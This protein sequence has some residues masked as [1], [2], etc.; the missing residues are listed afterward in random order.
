MHRCLSSKE[1]GTLAP[2][3]GSPYAYMLYKKEMLEAIMHQRLQERRESVPRSQSSSPP[4]TTSKLQQSTSAATASDLDSSSESRCSTPAIG[5]S[6]MSGM[7][8]EKRNRRRAE[9]NQA[10]ISDLCEIVADLFIAEAK[11]LN[12]LNYGVVEEEKSTTYLHTST[13]NQILTLR[14]RK[15]LQTVQLFVSS[16][17]TRYALGVETPSEVLVHMRLMSAVRADTTK[18]VV[19]I[20]NL[21]EP[22]KH[23]H[24]YT[25][26]NTTPTTTT[27]STMLTTLS[28][29]ELKPVFPSTPPHRKQQQQQ[30]QTNRRSI[31]LVTIACGDADGLL[32]YIT[33]L[34]GTGG[35][36][37]LDADVMLS[38]DNIVLVC[39]LFA[40]DHCVF[41][42]TNL[43]SM[44]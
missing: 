9:H 40:Y 35:S 1:L 7:A 34:L 39:A 31:R 11:L 43:R 42:S 23:Q 44:V 2:P 17:P 13:D 36:R 28:Y 16:L 4:L 32:E 15:V 24:H 33:K 8:N 25:L 41:L 3:S 5:A 20:V 10:V 29:P 18:A 38:R 6:T 26:T 12:P 22:E 21:D 30:T 19:H 27:S 14:R 37:V